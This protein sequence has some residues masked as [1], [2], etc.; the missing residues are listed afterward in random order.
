MF[1]TALVGCDVLFHTAAF[2]RDNYK[3]GHRWKELYQINVIGTQKLLEAAYQAGI[4][5]VIHTS[6]IAVLN[7]GR[8]Q[9]INETMLREEKDADDYYRSKIL[10]DQEVLKFLKNYPDMFIAMVLPGWMFGPRD[11]GPT[12]SG[13]FILN[14]L[15]GKLPG[16]V[17]GSFS[18]VDARDVA[19]IQIAALEYGQSGERYLAAGQH[20]TMANLFPLLAKIS[21]IPAPSKNVPWYLLDII[22]FLNEIYS[23][24]TQ[25]PTLLS[26]S[27]IK[28]MKQEE[29]KTY[30]D[31]HKT[32][33]K[34]GVK[35]R[36]IEETLATVI[37]WHKYNEE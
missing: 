21:G 29:H 30:F 6:S 20:M 13:E 23:F 31:H 2:F 26:R 15:K 9:L 25:K 34:L 1:E 37:R 10:A 35:F 36:P 18:I 5:R 7:G 16:I 17:P 11:I 24:I 14:F 4:R 8:N 28:L 33:Q 27:T 12:S 32:F 19:E 22:S 3:G